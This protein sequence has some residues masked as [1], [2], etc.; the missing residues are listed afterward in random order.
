[1]LEAYYTIN[2]DEEK[3]VDIGYYLDY[4]GHRVIANVYYGCYAHDHNHIFCTTVNGS[5]QYTLP[6]ESIE[7]IIP[8]E[9]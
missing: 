4:C 8:H 3:T 2:K 5:N 1:M 6:I 7:F 9:D